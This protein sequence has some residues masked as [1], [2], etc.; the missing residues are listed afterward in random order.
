MLKR[1][2]EELPRHGFARLTPPEFQGSYVVFS[3]EG[4][5]AR[6][7]DAL[8]EAK[9]YVTLYK[10]KIRISPTVYNDM[11]DIDRLLKILCA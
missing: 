8:K 2:Q 9:I 3:F 4:A 1:L 6:F 5:G 7:R 11:G 10:N